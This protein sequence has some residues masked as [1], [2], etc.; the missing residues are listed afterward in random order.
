MSLKDATDNGAMLSEPTPLHTEEPSCTSH[1]PISVLTDSSTHSTDLDAELGHVNKSLGAGSNIFPVKVDMPSTSSA[2]QHAHQRIHALE[3]AVE[4]A[5]ADSWHAQEQIEIYEE[6]LVSM[7]NDKHLQK[8]RQMLPSHRD[9]TVKDT[10]ELHRQL[11]VTMEE[12][13]CAV[14]EKEEV[15]HTLEAIRTLLY[16]AH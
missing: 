11:Y 4:D 9:V 6:N 1:V 12:K 7:Q 14:K 5:R 3:R 2:L 15:Q 8:S 16:G 13:I 10:E